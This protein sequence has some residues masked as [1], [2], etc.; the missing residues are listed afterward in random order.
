MSRQIFRWLA[1]VAII[2]EGVLGPAGAET[3]SYDSERCS[4]PTEGRVFVRHFTGM[5]FAFPAEDL[6]WLG[7]SPPTPDEIGPIADPDEPEGCPLHPI[8]AQHFSV[9][10]RPVA[11]RHPAEPDGIRW[12][13]RGLRLYSFPGPVALQDMDTRMFARF[14]SDPTDPGKRANILIDHLTMQECRVK[15][16]KSADDKDWPSIFIARPGAHPEY[17]GRRFAVRCGGTVFAPGG[18]RT[19]EVRYQIEGGP[20]VVYEFS[21]GIVPREHFTDFDLQIRAFIEASRTQEHDV[22]LENLPLPRRP[23]P[24]HP[25]RRL[26]REPERQ[27]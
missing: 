1:V 23:H 7:G 17:D 19:C 14:C 10:Y 2:A 6:G 27:A 5:S 18:P 26:R 11:T 15:N 21:D 13:P 20:A 24:R 25:R 4:T 9:A 12:R 8:V 22:S 16:P 3:I